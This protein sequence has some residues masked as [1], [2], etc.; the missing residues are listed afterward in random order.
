MALV[1]SCATQAYSSDYDFLDLSIEELTEIKVGSLTETELSKVPAALTVITHADIVGSGARNMYELLDIMVPNLQVIHH[2]Y[3]AHHIGLRGIL[4]DRDTT[5][6]FIV[7]GKVMNHRS[8]NGAIA[9]LDL[10]MLGDIK[11]IDV[12]RGS[13]SAVYGPG[14]I[15]GVV[16]TKRLVEKVL[17]T[18]NLSSSKVLWKNLVLMN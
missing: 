14:A 18:E 4:N 6:L 1:I 10:P 16:S 3:G 13:G 11:S 2:N 15:V 8:K 7:N 17:R 9:E 12:V 5:Y